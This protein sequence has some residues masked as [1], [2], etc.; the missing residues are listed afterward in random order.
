MCSVIAA[1]DVGGS[2]IKRGIVTLPDQVDVLEPIVI[3]SQASRDVVLGQ[4]SQA[5]GELVGSAEGCH[6]LAVAFPRPFDMEKGTPY[7]SGVNKFDSIYGVE[8]RP[9]LQSTI[10]ERIRISFC[11]DSAAAALGEVLA[12]AGRSYRRVFM[13]TLGT[14]FGTAMVIDG[15]I[16]EEVDGRAV[17]ELHL[18]ADRH[19]QPADTSLSAQGLAK[20]LDV[21][22][23]ELPV[24]LGRGGSEQV[25]ATYYEDLLEFLEREV[26]AFLPDVI[27]VG[28][29]PSYALTEI[30][31]SQDRR[32]AI[33]TVISQLGSRAALIGA[34]RLHE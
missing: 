8:L 32:L 10:P 30:G 18:A 1:L 29:G 22:M 23:A 17:E 26:S 2:S 34:A 11:G 14:G 20:R 25:L 4:L 5:A 16:H 33:P 9:V 7:L 19:G 21:P 28:G 6:D 12:G 13:I 3:D 24:A 31:D 15:M 27:V